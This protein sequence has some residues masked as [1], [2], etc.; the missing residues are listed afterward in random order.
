MRYP[1][2]VETT[3]AENHILQAS[4]PVPFI[5]SVEETS[6]ETVIV[7]DDVPTV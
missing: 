3:G 2:V 7:G 4:A 5:S 6:K 1:I